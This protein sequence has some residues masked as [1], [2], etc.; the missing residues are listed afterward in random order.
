MYMTS[1]SR[2][3]PQG[4]R[5][6]VAPTFLLFVALVLGWC[7]LHISSPSSVVKEGQ[8]GM[9]GSVTMAQRLPSFLRSRAIDK[10]PLH[11]LDD[12]GGGEV[13]DAL[14][15]TRNW[16]SHN[17]S[18][19]VIDVISVGS[20]NRTEYMN[21]Q[22]ATWASSKHLVR[23]MVMASEINTDN[24]IIS[25][26]GN[27]Q[28]LMKSCR[29]YLGSNDD[30]CVQRRLPLAVGASV[31]R[32]R[33]IIH[34]HTLF[35]KKGGSGGRQGTHW[36]ESTLLTLPDYLI[37]TFD[38]AYYNTGQLDECMGRGDRSTPMVYFPLKSMS[39]T[40]LKNKGSTD[41]HSQQTKPSMFAYPTNRTGV[42]F[43]K[44][45]LEAWIRP[46]HCYFNEGVL[47][48][49]KSE[50]HEIERKFCGWLDAMATA[51]GANIS[52]HRDPFELLVCNTLQTALLNRRNQSGRIR[53]EFD[54]A[55]RHQ[56]ISMSDVFSIYSYNMHVL[57]NSTL[58][59]A[60]IPSGEE[61][62]GYLIHQFGLSRHTDTQAMCKVNFDGECRPNSMVC[63]NLSLQQMKGNA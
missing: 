62:L 30:A 58:T 7:I 1:T 48:K 10:L 23:N 3:L 22:H 52:E 16:V 59:I 19:T 15:V 28:E 18:R 4:R 40:N 13:D 60:R 37:I 29:P 57:C 32:Y 26:G 63:A 42:V 56:A 47:I 54:Y 51:K 50:T 21:A 53:S 20:T 33:K 34:E 55:S 61:M 17:R 41:I 49:Y 44:A 6:F 9:N 2:Q 35:M 27:C 8:S 39:S 11:T 46:I 5:A 38:S 36:K 25:D 12:L 24:P 43:N 45:A 14:E 31:R